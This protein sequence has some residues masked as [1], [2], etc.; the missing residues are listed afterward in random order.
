[1]AA[2]G[3]AVTVAERL[4]YPLVAKVVSP[5]VLHKSDM[6]GV[7]VGLRSAEQVATAAEELVRRAERI[8]ARLDGILLQRE[9]IGGVETL[10]GVTTD[11]TFGPLIA[12]GLG[13]VLV[14][15]L[16]DVAFRLTPVSDLDAIEMVSSLRGAR[17]LD[18]Y[19]GSAPADRQALE[20]LIGRVSALVDVVP[21]LRDL[22]LNPVKVLDVRKG[23][24]AV[25]ARMR[26]A[27]S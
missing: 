24:V 14:E 18:G 2:P 11:P 25:D 26:I 15:L 21:E 16:R 20:A 27:K 3:D 13:G 23:A 12:C 17:L 7:I 9:I 5:D 22:D 10:V 4:G 6:G 19:R 8:G 1:M